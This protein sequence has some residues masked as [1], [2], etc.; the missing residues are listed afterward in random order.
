[1]DGHLS[2]LSGDTEVEPATVLSAPRVV[3]MRKGQPKK[4]S[5]KKGS[6][7]LGQGL[8][9]GFTG[10]FA[11][12]QNSSSSTLRED[13]F[14]ESQP[15]GALQP[16]DAPV[17]G[18]R[19][20]GQRNGSDSGRQNPQGWGF[21][22][23]KGGNAMTKMKEAVAPA[24]TTLYGSDLTARC[25]FEKRVVPSLI[26]RCLEEVEARGLDVEG[27]YR[28]SGSFSQIKAVQT[29]FEKDN[30][31]EFDLSDEDLDIHAVTSA[32][33]QY[34]RK[35]PMPLMTYDA[36]DEIIAGANE[37]EA[38]GEQVLVDAAR[39]AVEKLPRCHRD[40]MELLIGHLG[41][42]MEMEHVNKVCFFPSSREAV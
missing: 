7:K 8:K 41:R 12:T 26:T 6:E 42:V 22:S 19:P 5:W 1:M 37:V 29:A 39:R 17:M 20:V 21:L 9:K 38:R 24:D 33:K 16:G 15:Y 35:L 34:L 4:F 11:S 13:A 18:D 23:Q 40:A 3:D 32:L 14:A 36:Y 31:K 27:I 30:A 25:E 10:A 2:Q 28:K